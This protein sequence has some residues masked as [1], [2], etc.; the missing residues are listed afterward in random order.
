[1]YSGRLGVLGN[2][3]GATA[4]VS[5]ISAG[6]TS[7]FQPDW[8]LA[9]PKRGRA[10]RLARLVK[11]RFPAVTPLPIQSDA[12]S[13]LKGGQPMDALILTMDTVE[14]TRAVLQAKTDTQTTSYQLVGQGSGGING[15]R[16]GIVGTVQPGSDW[17]EQNARI[18]FQGLS[19]V[20]SAA[21]S[22]AMTSAPLTGLVLSQ[23]RHVLAHR[24]ATH[25]GQLERDPWELTGGPLSIFFGNKLLPMVPVVAD[26]SDSYKHR[27]E[28]A[29]QSV[30]ALP[31]AAWR[32]FE[33]RQQFV[34][35]VLTNGSER[36][37]L[38]K[39]QATREGQ[40]TVTGV[41]VFSDPVRNVERK[42]AR[43][44]D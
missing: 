36:I 26:R 15:A 19:R 13:I 24:S 2:N 39:V 7:R 17:A 16:I 18:F 4:L 25:L 40:R 5:R 38:M 14:D 20:S 23:I 12:L 11:S 27:V 42:P 33:P 43:F 9:D 37:E 6:V 31:G 41:T 10:E 1:M 8:I 35:G 32:S 29:R 28:T 30:D 22:R 44:T 21:S 34:A 3:R